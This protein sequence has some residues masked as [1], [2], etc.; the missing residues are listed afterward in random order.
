MVFTR[1]S[2]LNCLKFDPV[3]LGNSAVASSAMSVI[4]HTK[5]ARSY[6]NAWFRL[7][8]KPDA[9]CNSDLLLSER[10]L[11]MKAANNHLLCSRVCKYVSSENRAVQFTQPG[12]QG[13]SAKRRMVGQEEIICVSSLPCVR[14]VS[15]S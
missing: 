7:P 11:D 8:R 1:F 14:C 3:F 10:N 2:V 15:R 6:P 4:L 5:Q 13:L 12:G 9:Y